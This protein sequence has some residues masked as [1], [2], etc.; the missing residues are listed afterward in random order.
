MGRFDTRK[1][2][3]FYNCEEFRRHR[4]YSA[5]FLLRARCRKFFEAKKLAR[6]ETFA[7]VMR[8]R[9]VSMEAQM[10]S[11]NNKLNIEECNVKTWNGRALP[12]EFF[13][14]LQVC[15]TEFL[16]HHDLIV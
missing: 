3:W 14:E 6:G 12:I 11:T 13:G 8:R 10:V 15:Q 4:N 7:E 2:Q 1:T 5:V 16:A 9:Y